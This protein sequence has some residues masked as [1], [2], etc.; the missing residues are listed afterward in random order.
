MLIV[1]EMRIPLPFFTCEASLHFVTI[2]PKLAV[3]VAVVAAVV[4]VAVVVVAIDNVAVV[5]VVADYHATVVQNIQNL[6][7]LLPVSKQPISTL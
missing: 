4:V 7:V 3:V 5:A 6:K 2:G 1:L